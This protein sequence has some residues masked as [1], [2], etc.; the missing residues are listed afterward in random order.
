MKAGMKA[1]VVLCLAVLIGWPMAAPAQTTHTLP[2]VRPADFSGQESLVRIVNRSATSGTV[3]ITAID[4]TGR[5]FGP[6]T[7]TLGALRDTNITSGDLERGNAAK[8]LP[9]GVGSGSGSWRLELAT[10]LTIEPLAYIRTPDGF[11]TSMHDEAPVSE[12]GSHWVPFFN[13]GSNTSKVS[14]LRII[15]PGATAAEVTV[16]G[17]DAAGDASSGTVRLTLAAGAAR[18]LSAQNLERGGAGFSGRL[19]DGAG[20]WRLNVRSSAN[21]Q[22]MSLLSTRTGHLSNLSTVPS[23]AGG[24]AP[25]LPGDDHGNTRATA[26]VVGIISTTAG[27]LEA[28][29]DRDY[30]RFEMPDTYTDGVRGEEYYSL[31]VYTTGDIDTFGRLFQEPKY[32][33]DLPHE[34]LYTDDDI[35][36]T[37]RNFYIEIGNDLGGTWYIEVSGYDGFDGPVAT[38]DYSLSVEFEALPPYTGSIAVGYREAG[39]LCP[40]DGAN[41]FGYGVALNY[42]F[43]DLQ[44]AVDAA[45]ADCRSR[46]FHDCGEGIGFNYCGAVSYYESYYG[47]IRSCGLFYDTGPTRA[48]AESNAL[49]YC[50]GGGP[51]GIFQKCMIPVDS[52]GR[53][54]SYCNDG[55]Q[56]ARRV[57]AQSS[58]YMAEPQSGTSISGSRLRTNHEGE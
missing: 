19:G 6:V 28:R 47:N 31:K 16:T 12:E 3:R 34:P 26:T 36:T 48:A 50:G 4:D 13:P 51:R 57:E 39:S 11:L 43:F 49:S 42:S 55:A 17:R 29:G 35:S 52:S 32:D 15:N 58:G 56:A 27:R 22:V 23:Y 54:V 44:E 41:A 18:T 24:V 45:V 38:G 10:A 25:P 30:F 8:G 5:H 20:K 2:L 46:G 21:I 7:L 14:H 53:K 9:V 40:D 33:F 37:N 1:A